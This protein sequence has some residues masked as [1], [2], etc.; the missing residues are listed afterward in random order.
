MIRGNLQAGDR[1]AAE[2][3]YARMEE[4]SVFRLLTEHG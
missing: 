3:V 2:S 1:A 4:R